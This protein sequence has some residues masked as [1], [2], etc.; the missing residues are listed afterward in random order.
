MS[1]EL[2]TRPWWS[3][4]EPGVAWVRADGRV[5][6]LEDQPRRG[7]MAA[8][9]MLDGTKLLRFADDMKYRPD[10]TMLGVVLDWV[11]THRPRL[12]D[13]PNLIALGA[14][15]GPLSESEVLTVATWLAD[16]RRCQGGPLVNQLAA[17]LLTTAQELR[18][19]AERWRLAQAPTLTGKTCRGSIALGSACG[20]CSRC[21][22][23]RARLKDSGPTIGADD[24]TR[25]LHQEQ[26]APTGDG[27]AVWPLVLDDIDKLVSRRLIHEQLAAALDADIRQR[28]ALGRERYGTQLRLHNGRD[29]LRDLYEETMDGAVYARQASAEHPAD[30]EL[31]HLSSRALWLMVEVR[32]VMFGRAMRREGGGDAA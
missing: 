11:D 29:A 10:Q 18:G 22:A 30:R 27:A 31:A 32:A 6:S 12:D 3:V 16:P 21:A 28:D 4:M 19:D 5:V 15:S 14:G 8:A 23:E 24:T 1:T 20:R 9:W 25:G 7:R 2:K 13:A 17:R 26:P